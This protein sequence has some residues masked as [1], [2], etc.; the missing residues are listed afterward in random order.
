MNQ[1]KYGQRLKERR[2]QIGFSET[3]VAKKLNISTLAYRS[4]EES[5]F[6]PNERI[7]TRLSRLYGLPKEVIVKWVEDTIQRKKIVIK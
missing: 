3:Y 5:R 7:I 4:I 6:T 2:K 1:L